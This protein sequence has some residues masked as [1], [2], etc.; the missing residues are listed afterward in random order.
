MDTIR[1][2]GVQLPSVGEVIGDENSS[3]KFGFGDR[4]LAAY[5]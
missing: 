1:R 4:A 5:L 2:I 3:P